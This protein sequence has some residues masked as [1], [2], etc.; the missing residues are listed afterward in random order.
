[1]RLMFVVIVIGRMSPARKATWHIHTNHSSKGN[2]ANA[3]RPMLALIPT[4]W[5]IESITSVA[6]VM[7]MMAKPLINP[8]QKLHKMS[9]TFVIS[10]MAL[11]KQLSC[12]NHSHNYVALVIQSR[13]IQT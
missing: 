1:M 7:R 6:N 13:S 9:V 12:D 3:T 2:A 5:W 10:R 4:C 11:I 8:I